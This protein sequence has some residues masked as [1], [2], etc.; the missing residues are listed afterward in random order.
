MTKS[1]REQIEKD[2]RKII[3]E[4]RKNAKESID[5]IAKNC[6]FSRQKVWRIIKRLEKNQKIWSYYA[7]VDNERLDLKQFIILMKRTNKAIPADKIQ[8]AVS[9]EIGK[10]MRKIGVE[11]EDAF[12]VHGTHDFVITAIASDVRKIKLLAEAINNEYREFISDINVLEVIFPM[13]R[14]SSYNPNLKDLKS[15]FLS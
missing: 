5:T 12:Y 1:S 15:Y 13:L 10:Q 14:C 6:G 3:N 2:E 11:I 7:V 8:Q 9:G 4:L